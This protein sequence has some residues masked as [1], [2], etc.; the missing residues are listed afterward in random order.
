MFILTIYR[1]SLLKIALVATS[2]LTV[3]SG[4][5]A[6]S[7]YEQA[8]EAF[9]MNDYE[10]ALASSNIQIAQ[11]PS[12]EALMLRADCYHKLG[13]YSKALDDYDRAR[14]AG[15]GQDD[16][17]LNRGICKISMSLFDDA[18]MDL[19]N[20]LQRHEDDAK[21]YYWMATLEYMRMENKACLRYVDEAIWLDSTYADAYYLRAANFAEQ[22]KYNL[23]LEDFQEAYTQNPKL[24][25][26]KMN[27]ATILLDMGQFRNAVEILSELKLED[28]DFTA[29]VL[30]YR[31][32]ALYYK[33]DMEGACGDWVEAA[34]L[35]D[36]DAEAN[37]KRLC[38]DKNDK[39]RFKRRSYI[40]F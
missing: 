24:H 40:Q 28:I 11:F 20:Y 23:A 31:G 15:Y 37:Y 1:R 30:Y 26:A 29:E 22:K 7:A 36:V 21:S 2:I 19:M 4:S 33:H 10:R 5:Y 9:K 18:K 34:Q 16:L 32:E 39:P 14:L 12:P 35:G 38:I 17:Y 6:Q 8:Q 13:E 3:V 25:R 27:M